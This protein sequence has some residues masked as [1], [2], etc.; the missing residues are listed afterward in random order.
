MG[1]GSGRGRVAPLIGLALKALQ[2]S[3]RRA[4]WGMSTSV[5][6]RFRDTLSDERPSCDAPQPHRWGRGN[7]SLPSQTYET[8]FPNKVLTYVRYRRR[9]M[10]SSSGDSGGIPAHL[11]PCSSC[12]SRPCTAPEL[13]SAEPKYLL[14]A[15]LSKS[16]RPYTQGSAGGSCRMPSVRRRFLRIRAQREAEEALLQSDAMKPQIF[17]AVT[18][19]NVTT[20]SGTQRLP[21]RCWII[22]EPPQRCLPPALRLEQP[23]E[24]HGSGVR[25]KEPSFEDA[26][27]QPEDSQAVAG[28]RRLAEAVGGGY[29]EEDDAA[30][31]RRVPWQRLHGIAAEAN[32]QKASRGSSIMALRHAARAMELVAQRET[33]EQLRD[34]MPNAAATAAAVAM[35]GAHHSANSTSIGSSGAA[36]DRGTSDLPVSSSS[37]YTIATNSTTSSSISLRGEIYARLQRAEGLVV[38]QAAAAQRREER[39][40]CKMCPDAGS[41][42]DIDAKTASHSQA[43]KGFFALME[44]MEF[45]NRR[46][47]NCVRAWFVLDP[48]ENMKLGEKVFVRRCMDMGFSGNIPALWRFVDCDRSGSIS[49]LEL[50]STSAVLL[51]SF[52]N[53]IEDHF[54]GSLE[55][56]FQYM[57]GKR[58]GKVYKSEFVAA[59]KK[60]N[61]KGPAAHLFELLDRQGYGY[62]YRKDLDYLNSWRTRPY[63]FSRPDFAT[64]KKLKESFK[65]LHGSL[66]KAWRKVLDRDCTMRLSWEEFCNA[67]KGLKARMEHLISRPPAYEERRDSFQAAANEEAA[68]RGSD[69]PET[70]CSRPRC[71]HETGEEGSRKRSSVQSG[72]SGYD[73]GGAEHQIQVMCNALNRASFNISL[74]SAG[75]GSGANN[76]AAEASQRLAAPASSRQL[77]RRMTPRRIKVLDP[78]GLPSTEEELAA[79]WRALDTDCSGWVSLKEFDPKTYQ[80]ISSFKF[81]A[82]RVHGGSRAAFR[83]LD[84]NGNGKLGKSELAKVQNGQ[85]PYVG[86]LDVLFDALNIHNETYLVEADVR[87]L[88]YW[89]LSW[90]VWEQDKIKWMHLL[91]PGRMGMLHGAWGSP[92]SRSSSQESLRPDDEFPQ[93]AESPPPQM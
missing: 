30:L 3:I 41:N 28:K 63:L 88:D 85:D 79:V 17:E 75:T 1:G 39:K 87:F 68:R 36:G 16:S 64:L 83:Y 40:G 18:S 56:T 2:P 53:F 29:I 24:E 58:S 20:E 34:V 61:Y 82:D 12:S 8:D 38:S 86:K 7:I 62:F 10:D 22:L 44:F 57:D 21:P 9:N 81:W 52:K 90:E 42:F 47:G 13:G 4:S 74:A 31:L 26:S 89:D 69:H 59:V 5:S 11:P 78:C 46:Y 14:T 54:R 80:A 32:F 33:L 49:I 37:A 65:V 43:K 76:E 45:C 27:S 66:F 71:I 6:K 19:V 92:P 25:V 70:A 35:A 73:C 60:L 55:Q 84:G 48:E 77:L 93:L 23:H 67:C 50:D 91:V 15:L 72:C 51:A